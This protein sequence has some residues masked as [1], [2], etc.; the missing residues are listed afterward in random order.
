MNAEEYN[1][2]MKIAI[3]LDIQRMEGNGHHYF[4]THNDYAGIFATELIRF[5]GGNLHI[6]DGYPIVKLD[7]DEKYFEV[8]FDLD[9]MG[10][11]PSDFAGDYICLEIFEFPIRGFLA[12]VYPVKMNMSGFWV[13]MDRVY[14]TG[15]YTGETN[16]NI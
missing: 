15:C 16:E 14:S 8:A 11:E 3:A 6:P 5:L 9:Q 13:R 12:F 2:L 1:K 4:N 10:Y 7:A